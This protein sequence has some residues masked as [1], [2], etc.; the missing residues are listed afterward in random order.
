MSL[1]SSKNTFVLVTIFYTLLA[2]YMGLNALLAV[3]VLCFKIFQNLEILKFHPWTA[4]TLHTN[5]L[6]LSLRLSDV[7]SP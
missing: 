5:M 7:L 6:I 4:S 2:V 3:Y 1:S